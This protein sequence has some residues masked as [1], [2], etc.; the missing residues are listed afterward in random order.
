MNYRGVEK[1]IREWRRYLAFNLCPFEGTRL[2]DNLYVFRYIAQCTIRQHYYP[3]SGWGWVV[4]VTG[5]MVQVLAAGIHGAVGVWLVE[6]MKK[7]RQPIINVGTL[8][9]H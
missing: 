7:Y 2:T 6:G 8:L 3:E 4:V 1:I 5:V 9:A